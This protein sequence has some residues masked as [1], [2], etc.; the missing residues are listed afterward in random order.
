MSGFTPAPAVYNRASC[1]PSSLG[2]MAVDGIGNRRFGWLYIISPCWV[3]HSHNKAWANPA[4][5]PA[6][7]A[8]AVADIP[9]GFVIVGARSGLHP[10]QH[11]VG[12]HST[13]S[14][15]LCNLPSPSRRR[16]GLRLHRVLQSSFQTGA[17]ASRRA[18]SCWDQ[19]GRVSSGSEMV[20]ADG[21]PNKER[22]ST[23]Y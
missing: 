9:G 14:V 11:S 18:R 10:L 19:N 13:R 2:S 23:P 22:K 15:S 1:H 16:I 3:A 4:F 12:R 20:D 21:V 6:L 5:D 7:G 17:S 8:V